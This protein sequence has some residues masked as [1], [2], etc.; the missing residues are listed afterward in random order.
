VPFQNSA[1]TRFFRSLFSRWLF[2]FKILP[3]I[4][5]SG[6]LFTVW[7]LGQAELKEREGLRAEASTRKRKGSVRWDDTF[8]N[9]RLQQVS[10]EINT[11]APKTGQND[12]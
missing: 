11:S 1:S 9:H 2:C 4:E 5:F 3:F 10:I 8:D 12:S 7:V 6:T